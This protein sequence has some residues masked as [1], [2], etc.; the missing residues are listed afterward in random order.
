[1]AQ[2]ILAG[3]GAEA[4]I[5]AGGNRIRIRSRSRSRN[6]NRSRSRRAIMEKKTAPVVPGDIVQVNITNLNQNG[7]GIGRFQ[8]FTLFVTGAL[9]GE[10]V[11]VEVTEVKKS[12]GRGIVRL[13]LQA[14][15][16]RQEVDCTSYEAC[17]GCQL[18]H[19]SYGKQLSWKRQLVAD[20]LARIGGIKTEVKLVIGMNQPLN[21]RN[22]VQLHL[23][24]KENK[25]GI[26]L[27]YYQAKSRELIP[28]TSCFLWPESFA[29][30]LDKLA[31]LLTAAQ[32]LNRIK[33][34]VLRE[35]D[36]N[37]VMVIMVTDSREDKIQLRQA[38]DKLIKEPLANRVMIASIFHNINPKVGGSV[39]GQEFIR[40]AGAKH[41]KIKLGKLEFFISPGA[42]FQ[43]NPE[44]TRKLY[45]QVADYA[46][47]SG[48]ETVLDAYCGTGTISLYL[49]EKANKVVGVEMVAAAIEDARKN[50]LHNKI[51]NAQFVAGK[52]EV[53]LPKMVKE[54]FHAQVAVLDPPRAGCD[55]Q[56]LKAICQMK[57]ERIV[58]VSCDPATLARD[59]KFLT[60]ESYQV[61][62]VQPVDM[63]PHTVHVECV[64]LM[65]RVEK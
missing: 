15:P 18:L 65:S 36:H 34:V 11:Q 44:Q 3:A 10:E 42:F 49:A 22:K 7:E 17:G 27:G 57:P 23:K 59:L 61:R 52:A 41:L 31:E 63:F 47:L 56:V 53:L 12:F 45:D 39:L 16:A 6:R 1:M 50:A 13:L 48:R 28:I 37:Q 35:G 4:G 29:P 54:G 19:L 25:R 64:V 33:H 40:L 43:V 8:G 2:V 9:P 5:G 30:V 60:G 32:L 38:A 46:R 62:E 51:Q 58:Y 55:R 24:A 20:A 21:Y 26:N 14:A